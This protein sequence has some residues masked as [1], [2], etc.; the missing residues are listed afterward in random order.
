MVHEECSERMFALL[1]IALVWAVRVGEFVPSLTRVALKKN[2]S[3]PRSVFRI[4]L[5]TSR[6][7][8]LSGCAATLVLDD[9]IPLPS[10]S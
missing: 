10:S 3:P 2:G 1:V 4:G 8:S 7:I 5:D 9:F 6:Q